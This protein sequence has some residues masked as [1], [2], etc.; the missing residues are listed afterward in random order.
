MPAGVIM[1]TGNVANAPGPNNSLLSDGA[2][3]WPGDAQLEATLAASGITM[4]SVNA[5]VLEFDFT[6]ISSHFSFDFLFA[7]EEYGNFQCQFSDAFAFLLTNQNTGVT[8]NLAVVPGTNL[9]ISVVTIRDFLYNSS[10]PSANQNYFG[11]YNGGS[12]ASSSAINF[13]GQTKM[14]N[15]SSVLVPNTP[16]HIKLVIA[17][18]FDY[19]SDSAIFIA[20]DSFNIGQDVLGE[21]MTVENGTAICQDSN[22][23]L[24]TS[25]D[26]ALYSFIWKKNGVV[27]TSETGP[28]LTINQ[29]GTYTVIYS[30]IANGCQ[31]TTDN[32][33]V[34]KYAVITTPNPVDI[35]KCKSGSAPVNFNLSLNTPIVTAGL[36]F[37]SQVSYFATLANAQNNVSAL[38]NSYSSNGGQIFVKI[39]NS[40]TG[41][42]IIKP[43][44]LIT[45]LPSVANQPPNLT[46][47]ARSQTLTNAIFNIQN[48]TTAILGTQDAGIY[49]VTFYTSQANAD[50][51]TNG[52]GGANGLYIGANGTTIYVRV[53]AGNDATCFSTTTF[54]LIVNPLPVVDVLQNVVICESFTLPPLTNGNY[55]SGLNGTGNPIPAGTSITETTTVYIWNQPNGPDS[56]GAGSIFKVTIIDPLTLS[57]SSGTFCGSYTLPSLEYGHYYTQPGG[58]GTQIPVGTVITTSQTV[59]VYFQTP[60]APFC[61]IDTDF[62]VTIIS[63]SSLGTRPDVFDC[64][65]YTLPSLTTGSYFTQPGGNGQPMS[66]G[67]VITSSQAVY[68]YY[69]SGS[70]Q[71]CTSE[72]AFNVY[73]GFPTPANINQCGP[74][75][76]PILPI[77]HYFTQPN[78]GGN[79]IADGT[80]IDLTQ[81][82]YIYAPATSQ[83]A[84]IQNLSFNVAIAQP[85][86]DHLEDVAVCDQFV[87]PA[88]T[89]GD[90]YTEADGMGSQMNAGDIV[91][92]STTI[93]IFRQAPDCSNE[94]TFDI[95]INPKPAIDSR[96]DIDVCNSYVLTP[97]ANGNYYTQPNGQGT[98][99]AAGTS[100]TQSQ[101]IFIFAA[102]TSTPPCTAENT[103]H[104]SI[105]SI[106]AD[107]PANVTACDSFVLP[108]VLIGNYYR[109]SG[110]PATGENIVPA[111]TAITE[112]TT[113]YV[114]TES[115]ERINC[116]DENVFTITINTSPVVAPIGN[117]F[118]CNSYELPALTVGNY[119]TQSGGLGQMLNAGDLITTTQ[120]LYVYAATATVPACIDE[121]SFMVTVF[122]VPQFENVVT[123]NSYVLPALETGYFFTGQNGTGTQLVPGQSVNTSGTYYAYAQSPFTPSCFAQTSFDV[124]IVPEPIAYAV[125]TALTTVCDDDGTN[126][127]VTS[128]NLTTLNDTVLGNQTGTDFTVKYFAS[129]NDAVLNSNPITGTTSASVFAR[130]SNTLTQN[131]FAIR[132]IAI[133]VILVPEPKPVSG[134]V[135]YDSKKDE[136]INPF[137]IQ[138]GLSATTHTFEWFDT[139]NE[140]VGTS[141]SYVAT[142]PG[143]YF[144]VATSNA[145]GCSSAR[146]EVEIL[147]SEPAIVSYNITDDFSNTNIITVIAEGV[148]GDYEYQMDGGAF[149]DSNIFYGV[150]SG[151]HVVN[152]RDKNGCGDTTSSALVINYPKFFTPNGDGH[153]DTWNIKDL[154]G[155]PNANIFIYDRYGKLLSQI[156]PAKGGW[157]GKLA[158]KEMPSTDYWFTVTYEQDGNSK[159]FK[160]HFAMKR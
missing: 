138:S 3:N 76:L 48:Q 1:S 88:L 16:Y 29:P 85:A 78:G 72:D 147:P 125:P 21:D 55:F 109:N 105:F 28:T 83:S 18:R 71:N 8:T 160:A 19:R 68:V 56:C 39:K 97:L 66:A 107:A 151:V 123:C 26:A 141:N 98:L 145:T 6:P 150:A 106:E 34:E 23:V 50:A 63:T 101:Q 152:V 4:A 158:G 25:L 144:V 157:D 121:K 137:T 148:G 95:T 124:T 42:S 73:I 32:I 5:T 38:P 45:T 134:I 13:N 159:E 65:S 129:Q 61:V 154:K 77:G 43:F 115:G 84:C 90:Y 149:Q 130:V 100:I 135:C 81:T 96:S 54:Q 35:I 27:L 131:C 75:T 133:H 10:C 2:A 69:Q 118:A 122:T 91:T 62:D 47:C 22:T 128:F 139:N 79:M 15:A 156:K 9:P 20:S 58:A 136:L 86:V 112:T 127:G 31:A 132:A 52:I 93:Y 111:G 17:D 36:S 87:L 80:V 64:A 113:L 103:F 155:Q 53:Q 67:D 49:Q 12:A 59:Y 99:L 117:K 108:P 60:V 51:A 104:I 140:I 7:S 82:I 41:C 142:K 92:A 44:E 11:R 102:N 126:D 153:N 94:S 33:L 37:P 46:M 110:G 143:K 120:T 74:Y 24:N 14:M 40:T 70:P 89:N 119:F 116:T 114:Y 146:T 30:N 57:P